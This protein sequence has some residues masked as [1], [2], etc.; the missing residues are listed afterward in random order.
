MTHSQKPDFTL[1]G[2][3]LNPATGMLAVVAD[4]RVKGERYS[5]SI[6]RDFLP[7]PT[8]RPDSKGHAAAAAHVSALN[9]AEAE[10]I[11]S[12]RRLMSEV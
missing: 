10:R 4:L 9:S 1:Y 6:G 11:D 5:R 12:H 3:A 7:A 2:F 8:F